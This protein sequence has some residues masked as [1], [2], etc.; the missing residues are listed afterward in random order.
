M[1]GKD[2]Y[3]FIPKN[4]VFKVGTT[5]VVLRDDVT[6]NKADNGYFILDFWNQ[7]DVEDL[8]VFPVAYAKCEREHDEYELFKTNVVYGGVGDICLI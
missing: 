4:T 6:I 2:G 7:C 3:I 8:N 1:S 5:N